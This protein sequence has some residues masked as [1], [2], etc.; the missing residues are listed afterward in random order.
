MILMLSS[1][2]ILVA[3]ST[4]GSLAASSSGPVCPD[5]MFPCNG[6]CIDM[7]TD[8]QNCGACGNVCSLGKV[9]IKG[10][11]TCMAGLDVC[12]E[13]CTDTS[14]D[15]LNCGECGNICPA[16]AICIDGSCSDMSPQICIDGDCSY[17]I[18]MQLRNL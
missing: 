12:N 17:P 10:V 14:I 15:P 18:T 13:K 5:G 16:N 6:T 9:C 2:L 8:T 7:S 1:I 3:G 11:C 4:A